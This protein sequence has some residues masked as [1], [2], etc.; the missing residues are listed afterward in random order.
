MASR[1]QETSLPKDRPVKFYKIVALTFL[2]IT[3]ALVG[4]IIFMSSKRATITITSKTTPVEVNKSA[5]IVSKQNIDKN[6]SGIIPG[7]VTSTKITLSK[8]F[9]PK[10]QMKIPATATGTITIHNESGSA[11]PLVATTRFLSEDGVLFRLENRVS[12]PANEKIEADVYAD[13]KGKKGNI[14]PTRFTIPGLSENRQESVYGTSEKAMTGGVETKGAISSQDMEMAQ[15]KMKQL[16]E[17]QAT[18]KFKDQQDTEQKIITSIVDYS[19]TS[20]D[21]SGAEVPNF[22]LQANANV[23]GAIYNKKELKQEAIR[24]LKQQAVGNTEMIKAATKPPTVSFKSYDSKDNEIKI[25]IYYSGTSTLDPE[26]KQ[27]RKE[28]FYGKSEEEV[29]RY[30]LSLDNVHSVDTSFS[31]SWINDVPHVADH[32]NIVVKK[33]Q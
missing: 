16:V 29:R 30:L 27:I 5:T 14:S 18:E 13:Q 8:T 24:A 2:F 25:N 26:S 12:V 22:G 17:Q 33:V 11:Q 32:V 31:P 3:I 19:T 6:T 21:K 4:S 1:R 20:T 9:Q 7:T 28:M 23:A 15:E 10:G